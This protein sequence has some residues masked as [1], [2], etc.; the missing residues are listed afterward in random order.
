[1]FNP[2]RLTIARKRRGLTKRRLATLT[3][4]DPRSVSAYEAD[5]MEPS[6]ATLERLAA[7]LKFP[8]GFFDRDNL[9]LPAL[10]TVSFRA[11]KS[12]TATQRNRALSAAALAE[13][14]ADWLDE[15][16]ELPLPD[17]PDLSRDDPETAADALRA[18]WNLGERPI[19]NAIHLLEAHGVRVFS[20]AE[21][22]HAVDAFSYWRGR[23]PYAFLNTTKSAERARLDAA[24]E[25]GHL[26]LHTEGR[27][28]AKKEEQ[29]AQRFGA[30]FLMPRGSV[31]AA[32]HGQ[33]TVESLIRLKRRWN[34]SLA[35]LVRR[36]YDL[37]VISRWHYQMLYVQ[38]SQAGY[39]RSEPDPIPHESSKVFG[40]VLEHLREDRQGLG[41][42]AGALCFPTDAL[43]GLVF[44]L[45]M[46]PVSGGG[47]LVAS[48]G[49]ELR[50]IGNSGD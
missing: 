47:K 14:F 13:E 34:V 42:V 35:A 12:M 2:T 5:D 43:E 40:K 38:I 39:R 49:P 15:Q 25:L 23:V 46:L 37:G 18:L 50:V 9:A 3:G 27:S 7:A 31:L 21:E 20:L 24:H 4:V 17:L 29:E 22:C 10:Q 32:V 19:R 6:A 8:A 26:V 33:P 41:S 44:N 36:L 30:A 16:F 45:A 11:M 1:M 48:Q 28:E